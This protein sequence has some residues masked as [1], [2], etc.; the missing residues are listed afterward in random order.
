MAA[1]AVC[2][3][4]DDTSRQNNA[5]LSD[6]YHQITSRLENSSFG[7]PLILESYEQGHR[8]HVDV[9][10]IFDYPFKSVAD[11]LNI[12]SNWC[13]IVSLHPNV[14]ACTYE[15]EDSTWFLTFYIG[16][17]ISQSLEDTH[18]VLCRYQNVDQQP[19]YQDI[20][21]AADNGP[22]GTRDHK[23]R[24]EAIPIDEGRTFVHVSYSYSDSSALRLATNAY[25]STFGRKKV[26][27]TVIGTDKDDAPLYI[28]GPRGAVER[29][30]I[31]YYFAIQS[32][33]DTLPSPEDHR[34]GLRINQW[35]DF[36]TQFRTQLFDQ[37]KTEYLKVK[38]SE[39]ASQV[40][41]QEQ[42]GMGTP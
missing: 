8:M 25:F 6:T 14:K 9:Y 42:V 35:Y 30:A 1:S 21:L 11:S 36:T 15:E 22:F 32:F 40:R 26:G 27:F 39:H 38:T 3:F 31:R 33:M 20:V 13:D 37:E 19:E 7:L 17:N 5:N 4:A 18:Q 34:F 12:P 41:L 24:F 2:G 28:G 10:G 16:R 23:M 29:S